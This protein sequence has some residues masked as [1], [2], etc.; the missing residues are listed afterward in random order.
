MESLRGELPSALAA[1]NRMDA[2]NKLLTAQVLEYQ[3][4]ERGKT[5]LSPQSFQANL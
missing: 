1:L 3:G 2:M 5:F 4:K